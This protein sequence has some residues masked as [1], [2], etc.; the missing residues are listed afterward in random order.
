MNRNQPQLFSPAV[1]GLKIVYER[2]QFPLPGFTNKLVLRAVTLWSAGV[3][4]ISIKHERVGL[5]LCFAFPAPG[6]KYWQIGVKYRGVK[7]ML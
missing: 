7:L 4:L 2:S 5:P 3:D 6:F 1:Y